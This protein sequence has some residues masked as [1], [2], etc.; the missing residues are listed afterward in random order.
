[1]NSQLIITTHSSHI[2]NSKI[3]SGNSFN[4]INYL[5]VN[6][7]KIDVVCLSDDK[8]TPLSETNDT[9]G[10]KNKAQKQLNFLKKHI[11]YYI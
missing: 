7:G 11:K 6:R 3:H 5:N 1:M 8:V 10:G 9:K 2:L 4:N